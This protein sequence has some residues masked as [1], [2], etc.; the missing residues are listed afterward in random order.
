MTRLAPATPVGMRDVLDLIVLFD[1]LNVHHFGGC[2]PRVPV[3]WGLC[4]DDVSDPDVLAQCRTWIP[5]ETP[6]EVDITIHIS[7]ALMDGPGSEEA[8]RWRGVSRCLLHEMVHV[9]VN[10]DQLGG[11]SFEEFD[12]HG[13]AFADE[14]NRIGRAMG[15]DH[16]VAS[17][18]AVADC[19]NAQWWPRSGGCWTCCVS[20]AK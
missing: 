13:R 3:K 7:E 18:R 2:L 9:A 4:E 15:W 6:F 8:I 5:F 17:D 16:V 19:E 20:A 10:L 14:C 11:R 1:R 12:D